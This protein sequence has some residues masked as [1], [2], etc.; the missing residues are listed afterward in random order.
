MAEPNRIKTTSLSRRHPVLRMG[1]MDIIKFDK[2]QSLWGL[3][4]FSEVQRFFDKL[5][6]YG[7]SGL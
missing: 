4:F 7:K 2:D 6:E 3:V 5:L 1:K